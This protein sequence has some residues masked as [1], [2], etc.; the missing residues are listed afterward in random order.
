MSSRQALDASMRA[1]LV[2]ARSGRLT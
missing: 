1:M 2:D